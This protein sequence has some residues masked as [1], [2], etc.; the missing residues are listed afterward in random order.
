[1]DSEVKNRGMSFIGRWVLANGTGW[2]AGAIVTT[3][4]AYSATI[5]YPEENNLLVGLG[6]GAAIGFAQWLVLKK[7]LPISGQ[8]ILY[9]AIGLG[10]PFI[11]GVVLEQASTLP[12]SWTAN[13]AVAPKPGE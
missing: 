9:S 3:V 8:W 11:V 12:D 4:L 1:M 6:L 5:I 10:L 7:N 13:E 2:I